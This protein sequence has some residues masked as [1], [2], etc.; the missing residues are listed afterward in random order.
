MDIEQ[1]RAICNEVCAEK[2]PERLEMLKERL[3]VFL[4]EQPLESGKVERV[5]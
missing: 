2:D 1:F 4:L 3:R 5:I